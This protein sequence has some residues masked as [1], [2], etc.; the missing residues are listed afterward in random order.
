M[1][2]TLFV[3]MYP[4]FR[5]AKFC[6]VPSLAIVKAGCAVGKKIIILR[7]TGL[8]LVLGTYFMG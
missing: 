4:H 1:G 8:L 5:K 6:G 3:T 7:N 2:A